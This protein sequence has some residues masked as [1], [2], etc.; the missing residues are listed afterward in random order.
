MPSDFRIDKYMFKLLQSE[1]FFAALSRRVEKIATE[2]VPTAGVRVNPQTANFELFYNP[3]FFEGLTMKEISGV[4][5]HEF[6]HILFQHL[7]TR[8]PDGKL[9]KMWNIATDLAINSHLIGELPEGACIPGG[10]NFEDMPAGQTSEWYYEKIKEMQKDNQDGEGAEGA[11]GMLDQNFDDHSGWGDTDEITNSLAAEKMKQKIKEA[12]KEANKQGW[13]TVPAEVRKE[14]AKMTS[15]TVDWKKVLR[16][17]IKTSE[18]ANRTTTIKRINKRYPYIHAGKKRSNRAKIAISIDQS[19]SV[20]DNAL[21][22]FFAELDNL[23]QLAEFTVIP[24]DT[25]VVEEKIF[26][27]K[28]G[29]RRQWR[30]VAFGGTDFNPP[31]KYANENGF[32]GHIILTDL[33]A[34]KP[35]ASKCQRLWISCSSRPY[36]QTKEKIIFLK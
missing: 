12:A 8:V 20:S 36:F 10:E 11:S 19:G 29:E 2:S 1:P 21:Q 31:T 30:R 16:Y 9:S 26:V 35:I 6:Y 23:A 33:C 34:P 13:G 25:R 27:W 7:T 17:F 15:A 22:K 14:I 24:F 5:K 32:D 4:L 3:E 28:K 18:R